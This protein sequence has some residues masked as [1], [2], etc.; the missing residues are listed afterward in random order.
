MN[1]L[2][3]II[4]KVGFYISVSMAIFSFFMYLKVKYAKQKNKKNDGE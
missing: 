3:F 4:A 1:D 2:F